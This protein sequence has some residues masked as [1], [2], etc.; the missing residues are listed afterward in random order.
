MVTKCE[1]EKMFNQELLSNC[2]EEKMFS[3]E[4]VTKC[5]EEKMFSKELLTKCEEEKINL[6]KATRLELDVASQKYR[7][8]PRT[9]QTRN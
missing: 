4:L 7:A 6:V 2:E 3:K 9:G 5:E 1:E 8:E